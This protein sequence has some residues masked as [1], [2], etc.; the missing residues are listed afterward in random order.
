MSPGMAMH[1]ALLTLDGQASTLTLSP[2]QGGD[3]A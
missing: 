2:Y 3:V 1:V